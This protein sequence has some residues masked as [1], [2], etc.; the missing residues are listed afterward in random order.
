MITRPLLTPLPAARRRRVVI[1]TVRI[2]PLRWPA[3]RTVRIPPLL[4]II[5]GGLVLGAVAT[6]V[7]YLASAGLC[8]AWAIVGR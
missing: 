4:G 1:H 3:E 8:L 6:L 2:P 7:I 5:L